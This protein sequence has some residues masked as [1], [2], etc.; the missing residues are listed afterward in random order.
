MPNNDDDDDDDKCTNKYKV[1]FEV[2]NCYCWQPDVQVHLSS[3]FS[4]YDSNLV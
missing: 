4:T 1:V 2:L 3:I